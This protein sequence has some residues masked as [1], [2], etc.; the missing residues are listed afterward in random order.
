MKLRMLNFHLIPAILLS[1]AINHA[2]AQTPQRDNRPRTASID[3]RVTIG[4]APAA[5]ALVMVM[6]ADPQSW[7]TWFGGDSTQRTF[8]RVRTDD[9]GRYQVRGLTEGSY[10]I[11]ALSNAYVWSRNS[12]KFDIFISLTLDE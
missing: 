1:I 2:G 3:G 6:E 8:I 5:N 7:V 11:R 10:I 4:G 9:D 12:S